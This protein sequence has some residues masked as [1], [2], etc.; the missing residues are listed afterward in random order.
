MSDM[1]KLNPPKRI[2]KIGIKE[3][4]PLT[5]YPLSIADQLSLADKVDE[6]LKKIPFD[7]KD[8]ITL[9]LI[10]KGF[11]EENF[12][13]ILGLIIGGG[14]TKSLMK[15]ITNDQLCEIVDAV[16]EMNY[17]NVKK[18]LGALMD[19]FLLTLNRLPTPS[20]DTQDTDSITSQESPSSTVE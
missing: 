16:I 4:E 19:T 2:V 7:S 20:S 6:L 1:E 18:K 13:E 8:D 17:M 12:Q 10:L 15:K 9:I 11:I 5:I 3:F 14:A